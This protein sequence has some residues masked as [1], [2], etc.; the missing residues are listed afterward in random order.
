MT[1]RQRGHCQA[2]NNRAHLVSLEMN[3]ASWDKITG[4][5]EQKRNG[6]F[7]DEVANATILSNTCNLETDLDRTGLCVEP[8]PEY[9]RNLAYIMSTVDFALEDEKRMEDVKF[10]MHDDTQR[11]RGGGI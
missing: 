4:L 8:N 1:Y 9:W 3:E 11:S 5:F 10:R 2:K 7:V 6:C